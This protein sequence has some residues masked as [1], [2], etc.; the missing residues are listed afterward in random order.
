MTKATGRSVVGAGLRGFV[1]GAVMAAALLQAIT[2]WYDGAFWHGL[3]ALAVCVLFGIFA[4]RVL[5]LRQPAAE[6]SSGG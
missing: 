6:D 4:Y 2:A 5:R 1:C 3:A